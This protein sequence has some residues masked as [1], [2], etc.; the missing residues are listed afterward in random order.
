MVESSALTTDIIIIISI[1][2]PSIKITTEA[3]TA[4]QDLV[5]TYFFS[6]VAHSLQ[7]DIVLCIYDEN[8]SQY[9]HE[10]HYHSTAVSIGQLVN[11]TSRGCPCRG[12]HRRTIQMSVRHSERHV[13][14]RGDCSGL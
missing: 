4:F 13:L 5:G 11:E 9:R 3:M 2:C 14:R 7:R 8:D 10:Q 12:V 6:E 1:F